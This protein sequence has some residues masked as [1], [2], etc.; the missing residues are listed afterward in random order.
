MCSIYF[1][2]D[3]SKSKNISTKKK[4]HTL[5]L[6]INLGSFLQR[7][8]PT[9]ICPIYLYL[10]SSMCSRSWQNSNNAISHNGK[11]NNI[12]I[13][14]CTQI[15]SITFLCTGI[16][17]K[18]LS[19][20]RHQQAFALSVW[21]RWRARYDLLE[22]MIW[23]K[24]SAVGLTSLARYHILSLLYL[25]CL[26]LWWTSWRTNNPPK[27]SDIC[28]DNFST[29]WGIWKCFR[30]S[31]EIF[32]TSHIPF[33]HSVSCRC[34]PLRDVPS[35]AALHIQSR[36]KRPTAGL[37]RSSS[38]WGGNSFRFLLSQVFDSSDALVWR[39]ESCW[40]PR[41]GNLERHSGTGKT[42]GFNWICA[43]SHVTDLNLL[44]FYAHIIPLRVATD[45][46]PTKHSSFR[47]TLSFFYY[48]RILL[49]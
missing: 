34:H 10:L 38:C 33:I 47:W 18:F 6:N 46:C 3:L 1:N 14:V 4:K 5:T 25:I 39:H 41:A 15:L 42:K 48:F 28:W 27:Q 32:Y 8:I 9:I 13:S 45:L 36:R 11:C 22:D 40:G 23:R 21:P 24:C 49:F 29:V 19:A 12:C 17:P 20:D 43:H 37:R 16:Y 31:T 30:Y 35:N 44:T 26:L 7:S 2:F